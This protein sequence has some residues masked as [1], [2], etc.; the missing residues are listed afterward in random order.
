[1]S[2]AKV[3]IE[4]TISVK[5]DILTPLL[6]LSACAKRMKRCFDCRQDITAKEGLGE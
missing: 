3:R 6:I 1:M 5:S 2:F 4:M